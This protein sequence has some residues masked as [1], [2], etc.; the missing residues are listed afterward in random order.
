MKRTILAFGVLAIA[1]C[2]GPGEK[3]FDAPIS[4]SSKS[5][6][7]WSLRDVRVRVPRSLSVS[8]D[9]NVRYPKTAIVWWEDAPGDRHA[10]VERIVRDAVLL[11]AQPMRGSKGVYVDVEVRLFHAVTPKARAVG[12]NSWHDISLAIAVRD[13]RTGEALAQTVLAPDLDALHGEAAEAAV[14]RGETQ[15]VRIS[16]HI[17]AVVRQWLASSGAEFARPQA[18]VTAD[19]VPVRVR[20]SPAPQRSTR[21]SAAPAPVA[22]APVEAP[23]VEAPD[24]AGVVVAAEV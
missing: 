2:T 24:A 17:A 20:R 13:Q 22:P 10:Q 5:V 4:A 23:E 3:P 6:S 16:R 1:A 11:G 14:A 7:D 8:Q 9:P 21:R 15:K 18:R 12:R 19:P